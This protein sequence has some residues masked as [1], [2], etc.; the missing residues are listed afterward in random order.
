MKR[1]WLGIPL[2]GALVGCQIVETEPARVELLKVKNVNEIEL[3]RA[4]ANERFDVAHK[5]MKL[6]WFQPTNH[7]QQCH[8]LGAIPEEGIQMPTIYWEGDCRDGN[9]QGA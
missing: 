8:I 2:V 6:I 3:E 5:P 7:R 4:S 9:L 1:A